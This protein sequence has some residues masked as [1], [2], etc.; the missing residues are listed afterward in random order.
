MALKYMSEFSQWESYEYG[1][2]GM[3]FWVLCY[4]RGETNHLVITGQ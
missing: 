2:D 1:W 4:W 3:A